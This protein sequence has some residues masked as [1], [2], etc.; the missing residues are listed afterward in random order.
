M[1]SKRWNFKSHFGTSVSCLIHMMLVAIS[2]ELAKLRKDSDTR[3]NLSRT[4]NSMQDWVAWRLQIA[5]IPRHFSP[6]TIFDTMPRDATKILG[7]SIA[8]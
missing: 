7:L 3:I 5:G 8:S 4:S 1:C 6:L 2:T